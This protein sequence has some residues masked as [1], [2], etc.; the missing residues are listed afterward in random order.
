MRFDDILTDYAEEPLNRQ[1]ILSL[2]KGY[3][4]PNDKI[5]EP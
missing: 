2:I 5:G 4:R 1:I 3:K